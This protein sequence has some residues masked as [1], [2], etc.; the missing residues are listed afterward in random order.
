M[1]ADHNFKLP[2]A[3]L[4]IGE[5]HLTRAS[6][7]VY[8]HRFSGD[9][10]IQAEVPLAGFN[11][12]DMAV[13]AAKRA[14]ATWMN[15]PPSLRRDLL[16]RLADAVEAKAEEFAWIGAREVGSPISGVKYIPQKFSAWTKYAAGWADKIEGRVIS[17]HRDDNAFDFTVH[18][19]FGVI[20]MILTWNG[21]LMALAM[22]LG[23][24][25]A[26]GNTVVLKPPEI[27]PFT[28]SYLIK[29]AEE[30]GIP[31]GVINLVTGG[32]QVGEALV[33]H[34]DVDKIAFTGGTSTASKIAT[35]IGPL[36]K[37]AM[38]ELG[39][40]SANL[41]FADAD[42]DMSVKYSARQ[43]FFLAGQG[44]ILPTR[45]L[46]EEGIYRDFT[47][48]LIEEIDSIRIGNP[49]CSETEF[50]PVI[51]KQAQTRLLKKIVEFKRDGQGRLTFGGGIPDST[52]P[53]GYFVEPTVFTDVKPNST[54]AQDECFG[55]I[56]AISSFKDE[57][58]AV[59]MANSTQYGLGAYIQS[60]NLSRS[61]R[62]SNQLR[63]GGVFVNG[64]PTA[65][66]NAPFGGINSSG[67][68]REGGRDGLQEFLRIKNVAIASAS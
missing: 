25:L 27:S 46:V 39:G 26:T 59:A 45:I 7:G 63:A 43:P 20:G 64:A 4:V 10:E 1:R 49:M 51:S 40:K 22:K 54:L 33:S 55:P 57:N 44:C 56:I 15:T 48:R 30:V 60:T 65:R 61:L 42:M 8:Q 35:K 29:L 32:A 23:P 14:S 31:P 24:A 16:F 18:E 6:G 38:Y 34:P 9:G 19:P 67:F 68:G 66:E 11:E 58:E 21:P 37:P 50:G 28:A 53:N 36:L 52:N 17:T 41:V 2:I 12:V 62:L 13:K 3:D 5:H 47:E